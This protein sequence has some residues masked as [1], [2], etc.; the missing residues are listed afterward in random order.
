MQEKKYLQ[1]E[2]NKISMKNTELL[3]ENERNRFKIP[4][5]YKEL[6]V[7]VRN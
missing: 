5:E 6:E 3:E 7:K 2:M 4:E 1:N